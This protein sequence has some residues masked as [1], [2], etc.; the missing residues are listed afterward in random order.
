MLQ[1]KPLVAPE[2]LMLQLKP[3]LQCV[4]AEAACCRI[5][6]QQPLY[7]QLKPLLQ[8]VDQKPLVAVCCSGS[9][10][11]HYVAAQAPVVVS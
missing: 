11:L 2:I 1:L 8:C 9:P 5:L 10:L 4:A 7:L 6:Q 3:L